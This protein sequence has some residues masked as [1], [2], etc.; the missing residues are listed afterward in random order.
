MCKSAI[1]N[2]DV[3]DV[4][5]H[6]WININRAKIL[7]LPFVVF[8]NAFNNSLELFFFANINIH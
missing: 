8:G 2:T 7:V 1:S 5:K 6:V 3:A 4:Q